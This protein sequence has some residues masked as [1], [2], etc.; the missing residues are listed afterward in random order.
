MENEAEK[1]WIDIKTCFENMV[2]LNDHYDYS[3]VV[4]FL[5]LRSEL[6]ET[7]EEYGD[8]D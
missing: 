5:I 3:F 2:A 7:P 4:F 1:N 8:D 6:L